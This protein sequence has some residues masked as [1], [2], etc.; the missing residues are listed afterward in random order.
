MSAGVR[1]SGAAGV[2]GRSA[3]GQS[4]LV[5]DGGMDF[6]RQTPSYEHTNGVIE[7][8]HQILTNVIALCPNGEMVLKVT[9][10]YSIWA[11]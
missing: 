1:V 5:G 10:R 11:I 2:L 9:A 7:S 8:R 4:D 3:Y 6:D